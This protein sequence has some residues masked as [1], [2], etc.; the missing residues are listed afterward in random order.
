[1]KVSKALATNFG[2]A[3][4]NLKPELNEK[5]KELDICVKLGAYFDGEKRNELKKLV[6]KN[7][8]NS[9]KEMLRIVYDNY[10]I[11]HFGT[12]I[13]KETFINN[14]KA[15][16]TIEKSFKNPKDFAWENH[17]KKISKVILISMF[18]VCTA[19]MAVVVGVLYWDK[20]KKSNIFNTAVNWYLGNNAPDINLLCGAEAIYININKKNKQRQLVNEIENIAKELAK[21]SIL[22][23]KA[24]AI[25]AGMH[26]LKPVP[27]FKEPTQLEFYRT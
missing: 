20:L 1:M 12:E 18:A 17:A 16:P 19:E 9:L 5:S 23:L 24:I 26:E 6:Q 3:G 4:K 13:C 14:M 21:E 25:S 10:V 2:L 11:K 7:S 27:I 15:S 22:K 8:K